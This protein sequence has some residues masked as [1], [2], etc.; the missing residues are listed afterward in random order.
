MW[1]TQPRSTWNWK[2][3]PRLRG[4]RAKVESSRR[5]EGRHG[6]AGVKGQ[7]WE[8]YWKERAG[9]SPALTPR[10]FG[11]WPSAVES[12]ARWVQPFP[13]HKVLGTKMNGKPSHDCDFWKE[14]IEKVVL[15]FQ[16]SILVVRRRAEGR[17]I[18]GRLRTSP[19]PSRNHYALVAGQRALYLLRF[20]RR[21]RGL[22]SEPKWTQSL[23]LLARREWKNDTESN[24]VESYVYV[25]THWPRNNMTPDCPLG[26]STSRRTLARQLEEETHWL[27]IEFAVTILMTS[28]M[29]LW[30]SGCL[31]SLNPRIYFPRWVTLNFFLALVPFSYFL[32]ASLLRTLLVFLVSPNSQ[33][34]RS[35]F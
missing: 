5:W 18:P 3:E 32:L 7:V 13:L 34:N 6:A 30:F 33:M 26:D 28:H 11:N 22:K 24:G 20:L 16:I 10:G 9:E 17:K 21:R 25:L 29:S 15:L 19:L 31:L 1:G 23:D 14:I 27:H 8:C 2:A 12:L 4:A 35:F